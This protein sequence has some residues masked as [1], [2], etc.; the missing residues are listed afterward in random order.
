MVQ[1]GALSRRADWA[2]S[3]LRPEGD[4]DPGACVDG[5]QP[6]DGAIASTP[7]RCRSARVFRHRRL[8]PEFLYAE[9]VLRAP[10]QESYQSQSLNLGPTSMRRAPMSFGEV[11]GQTRGSCHRCVRF[12]P[13]VPA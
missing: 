2:Y 12:E 5:I 8:L 11:A 10:E 4:V 9:E 13:V 3:V 6:A 1:C 7:R